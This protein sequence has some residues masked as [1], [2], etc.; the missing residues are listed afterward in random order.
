MITATYCRAY[1]TAA[2]PNSA[3]YVLFFPVHSIRSPPF[4]FWWLLS[5]GDKGGKVALAC[6]SGGIGPKT[7]D[8]SRCH[9]RR[10]FIIV[11]INKQNELKEEKKKEIRPWLSAC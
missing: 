3:A 10:N 7:L 6:I 9:Q 8:F 2:L 11:T 5:D 4:L 1:F